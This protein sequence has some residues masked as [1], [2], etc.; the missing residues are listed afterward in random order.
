MPNPDVLYS[1]AW[2]YLKDHPYVIYIPP[3]DGI[4]YSVQFE[5]YYSADDAYLSTRTIGDRGGY[6]LVTYKD[7]DQPLPPGIQGH[8]RVETPTTWILIRIEA[9]RDNERERH[10]EYERKF[11]LIAL[12]RYLEDPAGAKD[13]PQTPQKGVPPVAEAS[14]GIRETLDYFKV[15]NHYLREIEAPPGDAGLLA[16]FDAAGFGPNVVFDPQKLPQQVRDGLEQAIRDGFHYLD[17]MRARPMSAGTGGWGVAP[18]HIGTFGNDY[19]LRAL[20]VFGGL[21]ANIP[22]EAV[23]PNAYSDSQ[24]RLLNGNFDYTITFPKGQLPPAQAFW[25]IT[26]MDSTTHFMVDN[27]IHRH[28]VGSNTKGLRYNRD[29]SLTILVSSRRPSDPV[30]R[31]NWLPS[32]PGMGIHLIM[33]IY[34]PTKDAV[35][36]KYSPPPVVRVEEQAGS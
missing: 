19:A 1:S 16:L 35:D 33:R 14:Y 23:Y 12:E 5:N 26:L 13:L 29:G 30:L 8:V 32:L 28:H 25:S 20:C 36:G 2:V 10:V 15:V 22:E 27:A 11:R 21:G 7:W 18:K 24:G 6:Y 3:M 31:A 17:T 9:T 34:Q 4:W